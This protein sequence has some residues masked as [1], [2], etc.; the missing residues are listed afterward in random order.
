MQ[1]TKNSQNNSEKRRHKVGFKIYEKAKIIKTV[2]NK[3]EHRQAYRS[4][5]IESPDIVLYVKYEHLIFLDMQSQFSGKGYYFKH[6]VLEQLDIHLQNTNL[7]VCTA[8]IK[9]N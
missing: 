8:Y 7:D 5:W 4:T 2:Q 9:T 6:R 1:R 3:V